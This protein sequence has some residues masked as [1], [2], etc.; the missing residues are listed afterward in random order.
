MIGA[1]QCWPSYQRGLDEL[2]CKP[3]FECLELPVRVP[4]QP[5]LFFLSLLH[6]LS[7]TMHQIWGNALQNTPVFIW[8]FAHPSPRTVADIIPIT[9]ASISW[10]VIPLDVLIDLMFPIRS[11]LFSTQPNDEQ[12][13]DRLDLVSAYP[14]YYWV[15]RILTRA[16]S[17]YLFDAS[18]RRFTTST[19]QKVRTSARYWNRYRNLG[20][21]ICRVSYRARQSQTYV[22]NWPKWEP[23]SRSD[24]WVFSV[25]IRVN[26][27]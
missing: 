18:Q 3:H 24:R 14:S 26:H 9:R 22:A 20:N 4:D 8:I 10:Y 11:D 12:E 23:G 21:W 7:L 25:L 1:L 17:S 2:H 5:C 13:Q 16:E 15:R 19:C 6:E 27:R